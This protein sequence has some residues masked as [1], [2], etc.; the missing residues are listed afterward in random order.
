[1]YI[2][3]I[4]S[5]HPT[6]LPTAARKKT[7][8]HSFGDR[9]LELRAPRMSTFSEERSPTFT[10]RVKGYNYRGGEKQKKTGGYNND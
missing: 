4:G 1:M 9:A 8:P 3:T 5:K 6:S 7:L 10:E 2:I